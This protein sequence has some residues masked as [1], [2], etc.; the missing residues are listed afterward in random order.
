MTSQETVERLLI[1]ME[2]IVTKAS[3]NA[4]LLSL[5]GEKY[6]VKEQEQEDEE[7]QFLIASPQLW[8]KKWEYLKFFLFHL[9]FFSS[10]PFFSGQVQ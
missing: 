3:K 7:K 4:K 5:A 8:Q 9:L 2:S 1:I 6:K 10:Y